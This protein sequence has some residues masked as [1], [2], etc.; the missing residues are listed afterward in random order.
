MKLSIIIS[1]YKTPDIL[2]ICLDALKKEINSPERISCEIIVSD[3]ETDKNIIAELSK[4]YP[5]V[6]FIENDKNI[7]FA[8]LVNAG[9]KKARGKFIFAINA[10]II[11][12]NGQDI[13]QMVEY[14]EKNEDVGI[15]APRLFNLDN[16]VQQTYFRNYTFLTIIARRTFF[17]GTKLGAKILDRFNYK[18]TKITEPFE[19]DWILGAAFLIER[20]RLNGIGGGL[21]ERFFMYFEDVDLC[22]RFKEA[23]LRVVYYPLSVFS[24]QHARA[25]D[26]GRGVWDVFGNFLTRIHIASYLKYLWKWNIKKY[27]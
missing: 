26:R 16:S 5:D 22:R 23:G 18:D 27:F 17:G 2:R 12:K 3:G 6:L 20:D 4:E 7:G 25:S 15:I 21:D 14:L 19:P 8:K 13:V 9:L 10:D 24:H 11:V 1:H